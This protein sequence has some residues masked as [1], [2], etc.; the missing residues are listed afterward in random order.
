MVICTKL[1]LFL[2]QHNLITFLWAA[3]VTQTALHGYSLLPQENH[4]RWFQVQRCT[5]L[6][7]SLRQVV[8]SDDSLLHTISEMLN[9][10]QYTALK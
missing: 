6:T 10:E 7:T 5:V 3:A 8:Y 2:V 1:W 4:L 9:W